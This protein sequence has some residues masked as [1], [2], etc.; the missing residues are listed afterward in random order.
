MGDA[1]VAGEA[2]DVDAVVDGDE[3]GVLGFGKVLAVVKG[4]VCVAD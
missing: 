1:G 2:K 4:A 3:D